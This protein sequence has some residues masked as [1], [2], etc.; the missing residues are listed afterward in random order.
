MADHRSDRENPVSINSGFEL[1]CH[2]CGQEL[3]LL[4]PH[5]IVERY[6]DDENLICEWCYAKLYEKQK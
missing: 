1:R 6:D 4:H 3:P 2:R 5:I